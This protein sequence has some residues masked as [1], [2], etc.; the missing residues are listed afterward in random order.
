MKK[1]D[2]I[3]ILFSNKKEIKTYQIALGRNPIGKKQFEGDMKTPEGLYFIDTKSAYSKYHK[4]LN[5]SYP[6]QA[7]VSFAKSYG[8]KAGGDIKIHG[9][10]NN[11][12][13]E[14]YKRYDWTWGCIALTNTEIDELFEHI[15][16]GCPIFILP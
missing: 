7:D 8:K 16:M 12:K 5:I 14:N 15:K 2:R 11:Y 9:L 4:N 6:N 10:P 13:E 3:M 1:S